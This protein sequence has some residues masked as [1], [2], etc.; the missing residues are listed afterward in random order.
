[1]SAA[2]LARGVFLELRAI[3]V[4]LWSYTAIVLGTGIAAAET[5]RFDPWLFAEALLIGILIQGFETHSLNEIYD[6]RSGTDGDPS[7]R[8]LS[9]G[10]R[11]LVAGLLKERH[12]WAIF[13]V[14]S[15]LAWLLAF[16]VFLRTGPW[17]LVFVAMGYFAGLFYTLPPVQTSY[18]P[19]AGE[20]LGGFLGVATGGLG[21]YYVQALRIS[22]TAI[23]V[24]VAHACV[25]VGMLLMHHYLDAA[26]DERARPSKR[27][28]I[29][30][31]GPRLGKAYATSFGVV[32]L[33]AGA[34]LALTWRVEASVFAAAAV[35]GLVA[36]VRTNPLDV[37]SV[38]RRELTV[39]QSGI[40]GGVALGVLLV[41]ALIPMAPIALV[42]YVGH[43]RASVSLRTPAA[44][45]YES[46][47]DPPS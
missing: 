15:V 19:F 39:I 41:P 12:L 28:T 26:A 27:T 16:D 5:G 33:L 29:V 17:V 38:T 11:V 30:F 37:G 45:R 7:P 23:V 47:T 14:S 40:V 46:I 42:L 9:G 4:L 25:C 8:V 10:S 2:G 13:A 36:H 43:V 24:A 32:A 35:V 20:W 3:P 6:W 18:R 21:A 22:P 44:D 31:L 34:V 1:M